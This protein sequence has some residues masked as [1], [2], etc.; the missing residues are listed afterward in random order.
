MKTK[1]CW[2]MN[3]TIYILL[4]DNNQTNSGK[5]KCLTLPKQ[6]RLGYRLWQE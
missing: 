3:N 1:I 2:L 6:V 5:H 4:Q